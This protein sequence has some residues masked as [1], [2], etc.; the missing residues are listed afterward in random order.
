MLQM[1]INP[2]FQERPSSLPSL[3]A[4]AAY[5]IARVAQESAD[6][7]KEISLASLPDV[8]IAYTKHFI[9]A[10]KD[11][12]PMSVAARIGNLDILKCLFCFKDIITENNKY[13]AGEALIE[14][15]ESGHL[16]VVKWLFEQGAD[17]HAYNDWALTKAAGEGHLDVVKWL[18]EQEADIHAYNELALQ[19]AAFGG[20][21]EVVIWLLQNGEFS[22]EAVHNA[23]F[24]SSEKMH[25]FLNK[26]IQ[27]RKLKI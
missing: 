21:L 26:F 22:D 7:K 25:D 3:Q 16:D 8:L 9:E 10:I 2:I 18:F 12:H 24:F 6:D 23:L 14:A 17:I 27:E 15:A 11:K 1:R 4:I 13:E 19:N 20:H 5:N